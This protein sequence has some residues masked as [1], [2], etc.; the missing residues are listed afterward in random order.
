MKN[1]CVG[2]SFPHILAAGVFIGQ[3]AH[4][5]PIWAGEKYSFSL[6]QECQSIV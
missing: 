4:N 6:N 5:D 1:T 3:Q 2:A